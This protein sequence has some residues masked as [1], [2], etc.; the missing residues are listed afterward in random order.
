MNQN[1][2][3]S[4]EKPAIVDHGSLVELTAM[5][6]VGGPADFH[7]AHPGHSCPASGAPSKGC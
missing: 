7:G 2:L 1:G 6:D 3:I 4:Y 5:L